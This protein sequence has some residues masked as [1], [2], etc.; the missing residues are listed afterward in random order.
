MTHVVTRLF[1]DPEAAAR[2]YGAVRATGVPE[3]RISFLSRDSGGWRDEAADGQDA[4]HAG[5]DA[6]KGVAAGGVFGALS[7]LLAGL[8]LV[9]SPGFGPVVAA[10]WLASTAAGALVGA[11]AGGAAGGLLGALRDAGHTEAEARAFAEGVQGGGALVSVR[12]DPSEALAIACLLESQGGT[13]A[14]GHVASSEP[15]SFSAI[16]VAPGSGDV[17]LQP[18]PSQ[19]APPM[20][21]RDL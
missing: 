1:H 12:T 3:E 20:P 19:P 6:G 5:H 17:V 10:G 2:A 21:P 4:Q 18:L 15:R 8:G 13:D 7:G 11:A 14:H 9:V 16:E